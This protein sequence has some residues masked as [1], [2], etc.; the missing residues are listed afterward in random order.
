MEG[1]DSISASHSSL[2]FGFAANP[3]TLDTDGDGGPSRYTHAYAPRVSLPLATVS[4]YI[5]A[6]LVVQ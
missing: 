5:A 4:L 1:L 6:D 3:I 2:D